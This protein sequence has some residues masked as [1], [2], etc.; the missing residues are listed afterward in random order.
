MRFG[1][2]EL[3]RFSVRREALFS[4]PPSATGRRFASA[5]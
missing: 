1:F 5:A 2:W 4:E 3:G